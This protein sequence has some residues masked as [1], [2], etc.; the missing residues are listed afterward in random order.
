M[1]EHTE[2]SQSIA[3]DDPQKFA[4]NLWDKITKEALFSYQKADICDYLLYLFNKH[5]GDFLQDKSNADLE[6]MLKM[7]ISKIK[8]SRKNIS[9]KFMDDTDRGKIFKNFLR[10]LSPENKKSVVKEGANG[11]LEFVIENNV[12][13]DI[14]EAKLKKWVNETFTYT[15]NSERLIIS[16]EA[17]LTMIKEEVVE[18][19]KQYKEYERIVRDLEKRRTVSSVKDLAK[20]GIKFVRDFAPLIAMVF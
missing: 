1:S 17:F 5:G 20:K 4:Q 2:N 9:V 7:S 8:S 11:N 19:K 6:K 10:S 16:C 15:L 18:D 13:K 3:L 12:L 14:L